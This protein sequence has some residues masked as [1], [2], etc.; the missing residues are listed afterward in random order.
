[1]STTRVAAVGPLL[2][3]RPWTER[4][5]WRDVAPTWTCSGGESPSHQIPRQRHRRANHPSDAGCVV[6]APLPSLS[7]P[8]LAR[9]R[10]SFGGGTFL[11]ALAG[12]V[13]RPRPP[14]FAA[15]IRRAYNNLSHPLPAE[16]LNPTP[17]LAACGRK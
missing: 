2:F 17:I 10:L 16:L 3:G 11:S 15:R 1:A 8:P 7:G 13:G 5:T 14:G 6:S 9:G 12:T 4:P